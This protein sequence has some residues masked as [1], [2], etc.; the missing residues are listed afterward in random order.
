MAGLAEVTRATPKLARGG[1]GLRHPDLDGVLP[2]DIADGARP[3]IHLKLARDAD[4]RPVDALHIHGDAARAGSEAVEKAI[5]SRL[6]AG[7]KPPTCLGRTREGQRTEP[8]AIT[9]LLLLYHPLD[10]AG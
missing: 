9:Q 8:L 10:A 6:D 5:R 3:T 7:Y 1:Q 4:G 2:E